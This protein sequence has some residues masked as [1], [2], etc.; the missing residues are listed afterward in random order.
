MNGSDAHQ[1]APTGSGDVTASERFWLIHRGGYSACE[2]IQSLA[3]D[4][5][6]RC[7]IRLEQGGHILEVDENDLEKVGLVCKHLLATPT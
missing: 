3:A 5:G 7:K 2:L 6:S 4:D 1:L